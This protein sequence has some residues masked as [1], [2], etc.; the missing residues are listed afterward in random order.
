MTFR[1]LYR[2]HRSFEA[3]RPD[4]LPPE[5]AFLAAE[6]VAPEKLAY[7]ARRACDQGVGADEFLI[8]EG[9]IEETIYYR[10]LARRLNCPYIER[11]AALAP[12]F[13]YQAAM[14][15]SVARV[16]VG[17]EGFDWLMAPRGAQIRAVLAM[18]GAARRIAICPPR[19]FSALVRAKARQALADDASF[20]L[21]RAD[22]RLSANAPQLRW[23]S[24]VSLLLCLAILGGVLALSTAMLLAASLLLSALF[25]GGAYVRLCAYAASRRARGPP[26]PVLRDRDLPSYT[27]IAPM[28]REASV[29]AQFL[30]AIN[31]LDYPAAKLDVKVVVEGD[32]RETA[33][34]LRAAGLPPNVEIVVAPPGAP[35]T[36]PRALNV[37]LPLARG[38]L[39]AIFDAEDRPE[40]R[41][42][43]LAA[44]TFAATGTHVACLQARL[45]IDNGREGW[46]PYFFA[47]GYAA[48]FD[49][50]N[51][52]L[53]ILG[54]PIPLGGTSN[55]FR[56]D[57]LR[58]V[59]GWDAW[60]VTED[61]DL[62]L[63]LAR[64][65]YCVETIEATTFEDA[66]VTISGWM[67][68]RSRW[69][70]GWMQTLSV[71]LLRPRRQM[72]KIG[73]VQAFSA[74]CA[75]SSL[76][77]GPMFGPFYGLRLSRDL[78][79]GDLLA[80]QDLQRW[81]FASLSLSV[82]LFGTLAF[83]L[84]MVIGMRRRG[85]KASPILLLGPFYLALMTAA[86]WR[87]LW[88]WTR[89]PFVWTKTEHAP[90]QPPTV[91][92]PR[93]FPARASA[94]KARVLSTP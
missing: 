66:P 83:V 52:G 84:P 46:L 81:A 82:A 47:I 70:K 90:R 33:E 55:H 72:R 38:Q 62:G 78:L 53:A 22:P 92:T 61:A 64:F 15:A 23:S 41:Q 59:V 17:R 36:K 16:D 86:A 7:A 1:S 49:V 19:V 10:A 14:R 26:P 39:L 79:Y 54:L 37:A 93:N 35:R 13:D 21:S 18:G 8:A 20:S 91:A 48:L 42:L 34:A 89:K 76:L 63:R 68:Q 75:M 27:I 11:A 4:G 29:A 56:T 77:A 2:S 43:R 60:N 57:I 65:G 85:L 12:G 80:P 58:R 67:G 71:F 88:E 28:Y 87:A 6:G 51:P 74:L 45:A 32:D 40:P 31:A 50:I 94:I 25:L 44:E 24:L 30:R 9:L 69:M 73:A 3:E 5:L